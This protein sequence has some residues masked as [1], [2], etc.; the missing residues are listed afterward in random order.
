MTTDTSLSTTQILGQRMSSKQPGTI[1]VLYQDIQH[2]ERLVG[3]INNQ[4]TRVN[5]LI[6][7]DERTAAVED[8]QSQT[9]LMQAI[10][11]NTNVVHQML[12]KADEDDEAQRPDLFFRVQRMTDA[13]AR[14]KRLD[15]IKMLTHCKQ[16]ITPECPCGEHKGLRFRDKEGNVV[17]E[18]C[19]RAW[20]VSQSRL[21]FEE[22]HLSQFVAS[23][24]LDKYIKP[25]TLKKK[26]S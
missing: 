22:K 23:T 19:P 14:W 21:A 12:K 26:V 4:L 7:Y 20:W 13:K 1:D 16:E 25:F 2:L 11:D 17:A 18:L 15:R 5:R 24:P 3:D 8:K 10:R 9:E 6:R